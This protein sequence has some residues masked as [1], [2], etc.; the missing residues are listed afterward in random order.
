MKQRNQIERVSATMGRRARLTIVHRRGARK[1]ATETRE[2]RETRDETMEISLYPAQGIKRLNKVREWK[3]SRA[4]VG[5]GRGGP[6]GMR[7]KG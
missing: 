1:G 6:F 4:D 3:K 7:G 5:Q 2:T